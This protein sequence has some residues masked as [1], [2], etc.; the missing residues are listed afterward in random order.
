VDAGGLRKEWFLL[1]TRE[2]FD[3][4]HGMFGSSKLFSTAWQVLIRCC[5]PL[6]LRRGF[7]IL[8]F[9]PILFRVV[10]TVLPC[11]SLARPR[12]LQLDNTRFG[13]TSLCL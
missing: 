13:T 9:Q 6:S 3:P 1:L 12:H 8:L 5:R 4:L 11:R 10:G 2:I 7:S